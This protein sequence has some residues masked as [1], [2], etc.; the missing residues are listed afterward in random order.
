MK[1][2]GA[3]ARSALASNFVALATKYAEGSKLECK[4]NIKRRAYAHLSSLVRMKGLEPSRLAALAPK[5]SV[6]TNST[7]SARPSVRLCLVL[8]QVTKAS[9]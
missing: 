7:T 5:A 1:G 4:R 2:L 9:T 3:E 8:S 6:S